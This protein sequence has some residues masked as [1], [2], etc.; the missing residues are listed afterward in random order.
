[1]T[2]KAEIA[3]TP[4]ARRVP[5][6]ERSRRRVESILDAAALVFAEDGF[7]AATTEAIAEKAGTSIGSLYQFF[8]N[9]LALFEA[10]AQRCV[11]RS[12]DAFEMLFP[13]ELAPNEWS[14]VLD[15]ILSGFALLHQADPSFRA[16]LVNFQLYGVY[17]E[18][19]SVLHRHI[20]EKISGVL[21][22][23]APGLSPARHH[24]VAKLIVTTVAALF[25]ASQRDK[26]EAVDGLFEEAK[27]MLRRYIEGYAQH[28]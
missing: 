28:G 7:E 27:I 3:T 21:G 22:K 17:S 18:A 11:D 13:K 23:I 9:K 24:S 5:I 19:D 15:R 1:M 20:V 16:V 10:L 6:Q 25:L 2:R 4:V 26:P 14:E 12:R 8:P